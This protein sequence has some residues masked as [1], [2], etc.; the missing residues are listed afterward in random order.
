MKG[1]ILLIGSVL[2]TSYLLM[3]L[4]SVSAIE[5]NTVIEKN[6]FELLEELKDKIKDGGLSFDNELIRIL[7]IFSV[8]Y[9][10][11]RITMYIIGILI[12]N[13]PPST[14]SRPSPA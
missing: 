7:L 10:L 3:I 1:R 14:P 2:I 13:T 4:P 12:G 5:H 9:V 8:F 6:K 11:Y